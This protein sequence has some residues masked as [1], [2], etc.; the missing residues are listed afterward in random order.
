MVTIGRVI[1]PHDF[2]SFPF[3]LGLYTRLCRV[4]FPFQ[5][6]PTIPM[7]Y[8]NTKVKGSYDPGCA[9]FA[10]VYHDN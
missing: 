5:V 1:R 3:Q 10:A 4:R 2:D 6:R 7:I 8:E 9:L